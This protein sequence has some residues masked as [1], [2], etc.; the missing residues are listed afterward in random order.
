MLILIGAG[1]LLWQLTAPQAER[2]DRAFLPL[3]A[4]LYTFGV[5]TISRIDPRL[6]AHHTINML[7]GLVIVIAGQRFYERYERLARVTYP[8]VVI[9]LA[10]FVLLRFF[11]RDVN[12]AK[13]WFSFSVFN[14]QPVEFIKL[15]MVFF[16]AAYLARNGEAI[17]T[18]R[19]S[20]LGENLRLFGPLLLAWGV[21]ILSLALQHDVG[22]AILF[23]SIFA[24]MLYAASRRL[25]VVLLSALIFAASMWLVAAHYPYVQTRLAV[26][27][28]PWSDPLGRSYQAEQGF[29]SLAAGGLLGTGYHLGHPNFIPDAASDYV[30][31]AL[32]E[33]F[34]LL[35]GLTVLALYLALVVRAMRTA[36]YAADRFTSLLATGFAAALAVQVLVIVGG[37]VGLLPLTGITLPFISYGGSSLVANLLMIN[38]LWLFS[39]KPREPAPAH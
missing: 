19:F 21:S 8:W 2:A 30:F 31:A 29:F 26:W 5:L 16:M 6:G 3:V 14:V 38:L 33:E 34:G 25:D 22:M 27:R 18:L 20:S 9:S 24:V 7:V 39:R 11:G 10:L 1:F 32:A 12:G 23:L 4:A 15:F 17:A 13:L 28:D 37:V 36:F 35:G